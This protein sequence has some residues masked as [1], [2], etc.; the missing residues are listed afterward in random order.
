[1][2]RPTTTTKQTPNTRNKTTMSIVSV[3]T[4]RIM[5]KSEKWNWMIG[6]WC[7]G[8]G[9]WQLRVWFAFYINSSF[10]R[11]TLHTCAQINNEQDCVCVWI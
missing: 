7:I 6:W 4:T 8:N 2:D 10:I 9:N 11:R 5:F 3:D 1:M